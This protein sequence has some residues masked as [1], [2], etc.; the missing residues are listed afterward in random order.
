MSNFDYAIEKTLKHE[1]G[2]VHNPKDPGGQTNFGISARAHPNLDIK[3]LTRE[4]AIAIY[5]KY[6]WRPL[7]DDIAGKVIAAKVFDMAVLMGHKAVHRCLQDSVNLCG[8]NVAVD[9][10]LGS[11]TI[12]AVNNVEVNELLKELKIQLLERIRR[13]IIAKPTSKVFE[14]GWKSRIMS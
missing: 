5:K 10:L 1:G 11:Q 3:N 13:I 14:K 2:Y 4:E 12:D 8:Q 6:Y 9:G 7:Y